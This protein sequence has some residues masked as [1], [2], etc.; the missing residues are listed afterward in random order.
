MK[1]TSII[2]SYNDF[3]GKHLN[4]SSFFSFVS[5]KERKGFIKKIKKRLYALIDRSAGL[6][7]ANKFQI[8]SRHSMTLS[9]RFMV[10]WNITGLQT[11][12]LFLTSLF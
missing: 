10:H 8:A 12:S 4:L 5:R 1:Q 2:F 7:F 11:K 3:K 9:F 6:P